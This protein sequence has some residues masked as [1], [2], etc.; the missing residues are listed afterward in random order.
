MPQTANALS[1]TPVTLLGI[2]MVRRLLH[3]A[4]AILPI[5]V[6]PSPHVTL[7]KLMQL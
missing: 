6:M 2:L 5:S 1:L 7:V 3:S 4:K